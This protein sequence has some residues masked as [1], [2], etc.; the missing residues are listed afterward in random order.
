MCESKTE[1]VYEDLSSD[2]EMVDF[3]NYSTNTIK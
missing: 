1:V 2:K 3:I